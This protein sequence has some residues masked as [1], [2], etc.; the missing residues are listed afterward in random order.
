MEACLPLHED[1]N[2]SGVGSRGGCPLSAPQSPDRK[3]CCLL[4]GASEGP[5]FIFLVFLPVSSLSQY[6]HI[7]GAE[8]GR[9]RGE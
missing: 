7:G 2:A 6:H 4:S 1:G 8:L 9:W 5:L 3:E